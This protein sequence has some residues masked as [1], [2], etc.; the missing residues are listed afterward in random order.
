MTNLSQDPNQWRRCVLDTN[1]LIYN[2]HCITDDTL[3][4]VHVYIPEIVITE[5]EK[6]KKEDTARGFAAREVVTIMR[7][8]RELGNL[9]AGVVLDSGRIVTRIKAHQTKNSPVPLIDGWDLRDPDQ[10]I[11]RTAVEL[12]HLNEERRW[13]NEPVVL[14]TSD[15]F[16]ADKADTCGVAVWEIVD[17]SLNDRYTGQRE[18]YCGGKDYNRLY[19]KKDWLLDP[20]VLVNESEEPITDL[21]VNEF[22]IIR[23]LHNPSLYK[24]G[25][26]AGASIVPLKH[27]Q[28]NLRGV[29]ARN[30]AQKFIFESLLVESGEERLII[31][32][33]PAGT[34]KT[35][36]SLA[37]GMYQKRRAQFDH[38][39]VTRANVEADSSFGFLPGSLE[40][41][42]DGFL[43]P[44]Y[45]NLD[46]IERI[47]KNFKQTEAAQKRAEQEAKR[48][49]RE[50]AKITQ[51]LTVESG[52]V[53]IKTK[54]KTKTRIGAVKEA[55]PRHQKSPTTPPPLTDEE[56]LKRLADRGIEAQPLNYMRGRTL[57]RSFILVDEAQNLTREQAKM[58]VT[59][60][61]KGSIVVLLGDISQIDT[62][63]LNRFNNG[64]AH[65]FNAMADE[66]I[67]W[68]LR[69]QDPDNQRSLL[70][71]IA[72]SKL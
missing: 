20:S 29:T 48:L 51:A 24:L 35:I 68:R 66:S 2:P 52:T 32:E 49:A 14:V 37:A 45:D 34:G 8:L 72:A 16:L 43:N 31:V 21:H 6:F 17:D 55:K 28:D 33:G 23:N 22:L 27:E 18:V 10:I 64:L 59:R 46:A 19:R 70:S 3:G 11:L 12:Q 61:D 15:L 30:I 40:A 67:C 41:K 42:F 54:E 26:C 56:K 9:N 39:Y 47:E 60:A 1:A 69:T 63:K 5:L 25:R 4:H 53:S 36:L 62:S 7:D 71:R 58:I 44:I 65:A 57:Y 50:E 13:S 38:F